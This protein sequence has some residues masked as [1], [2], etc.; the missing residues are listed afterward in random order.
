MVPVAAAAVGATLGAGFDSLGGA[1]GN[2]MVKN[3]RRVALS[4]GWCMALA[5][6]LYASSSWLAEVAEKNG[7]GS[8]AIYR[9]GPER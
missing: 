1:I 8:M 4:L 9:R 7:A 5:V 2:A 3:D 6:V